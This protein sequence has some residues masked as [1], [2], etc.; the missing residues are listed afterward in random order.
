MRNGV[1]RGNGSTVTRRVYE[2]VGEIGE[3]RTKVGFFPVGKNDTLGRERYLLQPDI[4]I[5]TS[6]ELN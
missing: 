5:L 3:S 2:I 4:I 1:H 6:F